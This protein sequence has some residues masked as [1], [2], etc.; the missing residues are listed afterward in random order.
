VDAS[1]VKTH[2]ILFHTHIPFRREVRS[3]VDVTYVRNVVRLTS[4]HR[5]CCD[6]RQ[7]ELSRIV[8]CA[9]TGGNARDREKDTQWTHAYAHRS[10]IWHVVCEVRRVKLCNCKSSIYFRDSCHNASPPDLLLSID[11]GLPLPISF[12]HRNVHG[13]NWPFELY[14]IW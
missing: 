3:V 2:N 13:R 10:L 9:K 1:C 8:D 14:L 11:P 6:F 7:C 12:G 5:S 4:C